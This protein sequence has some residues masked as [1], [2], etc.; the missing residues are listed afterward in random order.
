MG[1]CCWF[2]SE[3]TSVL[4]RRGRDKK[5]HEDSVR[6]SHVHTEQRAVWSQEKTKPPNAFVLDFHPT[7]LWESQFLLLKS[8]PIC[9]I[10][11][12]NPSQVTQS[13]KAGPGLR[14]RAKLWICPPPPPSRLFLQAS[15]VPH[16]L[17]WC[18]SSGQFPTYLPTYL[19]VVY[20]PV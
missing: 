20:P 8:H 12:G 16:S 6:R 1:P 4:S 11:S 5:A 3:R 17:G 9:R 18:E 7:Q 15:E 2:Q 13:L 19:L 10:L 14:V